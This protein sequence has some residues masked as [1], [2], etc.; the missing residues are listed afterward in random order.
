M[1]PEAGCTCPC[2]KEVHKLQ[3][4]LDEI[5]VIIQDIKE[6]LQW[7]TNEE[8]ADDSYAPSEED[9]LSEDTLSEAEDL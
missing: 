2:C 7:L 1:H 6:T 5:F 4:I 8:E 3:Q 9:C